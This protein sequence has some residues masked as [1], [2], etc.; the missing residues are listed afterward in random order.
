MGRKC[1]SRPKTGIPILDEFLSII[2]ENGPRFVA[3]E[4]GLREVSIWNWTTGKSAPTL[5]SA[6][7]ALNAM[8]YEL[9]IFEMDEPFEEE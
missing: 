8:G 7:K 3:A 9:V 5:L 1:K 6:Q 2:R 4:S